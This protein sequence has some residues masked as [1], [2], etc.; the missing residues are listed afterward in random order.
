[1]S[2]DLI[3][4]RSLTYAQRAVRALEGAGI[5]AV[6]ARAPQIYLDS[7]CG[8]CA[9]ISEKASG[10]CARCAAKDRHL[11][12]P[13]AP[14]GAR[15]IFPGG[16]AVIYLDAAATSLQKPESVRTAVN[17]AMRLCAS[18]GRGSHAAAQAAADIVFACRSAAAGLFG[19]ETPEKVVFTLNATHALNIAISSL[20]RPGDRVV[21]SGYEHNAVTRPL[22]ALGA[23]VDVAR[24]RTVR[25]GGGGPCLRGAAARGALRC[26]QPCVKRFSGLSCPWS[27]L[28]GFAGTRGVPLVIDASQSAGSLPLDCRELGAAFIAMP[29]HKGLMGPQGT[30]MLLCRDTGRP[31]LFG[32]TGSASA[33]QDMPP[34]LPDR[35]EA[36]THNVP[37]IA[38][39][40]A[41]IEAVQKVGLTK[42][43]QHE[44]RLTRRMGEEL[45]GIHG[46]RVFLSPTLSAQAGVLSVKPES[47]SCEALAES[48]GE[49]GVA[50]P[51]APVCTAP[52]ARMKRPAR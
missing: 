27:V 9:R 25:R 31:V 1:M 40:L 29:G 12:G 7:G 50:V 36:G 13:C 35:L 39:L 28:R 42:I 23:Q 37:G 45:A 34:F 15:G 8:Y 38:G 17:R 33:S 4:C 14:A 2:Y 46:L 10:G 19:L 48:L 51:S 44:Q 21:V 32:G 6:V 11:S 20:V 24:V 43:L 41:G 47:C 52:P 18:P 16:R 49:R 26:L 22:H 5:T 30:G 3:L